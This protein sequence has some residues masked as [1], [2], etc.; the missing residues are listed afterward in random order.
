VTK[1]GGGREKERKIARKR[2]T[3]LAIHSS[4][5]FAIPCFL[6]AQHQ[7]SRHH[8]NDGIKVS[9]AVGDG[10]LACNATNATAIYHGPAF[11]S[12]NTFLQE[13][14]SVL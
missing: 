14:V 11:F 13:T 2:L 7:L 1:G 3:T 6:K 5:V 4:S 12:R 10:S 9:T 8:R